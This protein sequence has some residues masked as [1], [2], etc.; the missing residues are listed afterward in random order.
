[1]FFVYLD[2]LPPA[3]GL[4][5]I[6]EY[7]EKDFCLINMHRIVSFSFEF[8][9]FVSALVASVIMNINIDISCYHMMLSV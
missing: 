5:T 4:K 7:Y 2:N 6:K 1:M 3:E 8:L 9:F